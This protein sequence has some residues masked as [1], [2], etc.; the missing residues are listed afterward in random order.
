MQEK[1]R[2]PRVAV[3]V[4]V[5]CEVKG[6]ASFQ[7]VVVDVSVG[8]LYIE[9]ETAPAFG[10][11]ILLTGD[12]PGA[13]GL[14]LPAIVRWG[15]PGGFGVQFGLLGAKETHALTSIMQKARS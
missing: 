5:T 7:G 8:G 15:K 3:H 14:K 13:P 9:A 11:D 4:S 12:F 2:H 10:G 6:A 1:R